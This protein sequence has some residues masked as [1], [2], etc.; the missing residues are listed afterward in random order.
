[1]YIK[2]KD[3]ASQVKKKKCWKQKFND[4]KNNLVI[5]NLCV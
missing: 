3:L 5:R 4:R 1:M 2:T